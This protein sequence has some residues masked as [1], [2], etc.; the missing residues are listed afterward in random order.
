M[1]RYI[2]YMYSKVERVDFSVFVI[3]FVLYNINQSENTCLH[4]I[5][6]RR[7]TTQS[8]IT[9]FPVKPHL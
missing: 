6:R 1:R 9:K 8:L 4:I 3:L 5:Y 7:M 2:D